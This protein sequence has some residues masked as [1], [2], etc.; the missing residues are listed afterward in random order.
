MRAVK[1]LRSKKIPATLELKGISTNNKPDSFP[2]SGIRIMGATQISSG[3]MA[4]ALGLVDLVMT[5]T[6]YDADTKKFGDSYDKVVSLTLAC[7]PLWC[8]IWI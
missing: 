7:S 3:V 2:Y 6:S 4:F 8:G 1:N 5:L